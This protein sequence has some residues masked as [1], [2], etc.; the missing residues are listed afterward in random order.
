MPCKNAERPPTVLILEYKPFIMSSTVTDNSRRAVRIC[1][2]KCRAGDPYII[3]L[4]SPTSKDLPERL[5]SRNAQLFG[6]KA[7]EIVEFLLKCR[8]TS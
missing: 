2:P 4:I 5:S 3:L 6:K 8:N 1:R 7:D